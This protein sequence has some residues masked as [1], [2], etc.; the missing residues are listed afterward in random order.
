MQI[1]H[2]NRQHDI[3]DE[4]RKSGILQQ[5]SDKGDGGEKA[6]TAPDADILRRILDVLR[7]RIEAGAA[8]FLIKINQ[9]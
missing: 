4:A 2:G 9:D 1:Q 8:T 5:E 3:S 7:E 6:A